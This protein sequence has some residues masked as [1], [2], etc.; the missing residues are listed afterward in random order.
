LNGHG[1][2]VDS[3]KCIC[4][5][6]NAGKENTDPLKGDA[7]WVYKCG[8]SSGFE[9]HGAALIVNKYSQPSVVLVVNI[10]SL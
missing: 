4:S 9:K 10:F 5:T 8:H 2:L 7:R 6:T 1:T 3:G